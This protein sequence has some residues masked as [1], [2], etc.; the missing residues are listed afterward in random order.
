MIDSTLTL[1]NASAGGGISNSGALTVGNTI[2]SNNR[3]NNSG[4]AITNIASATLTISGGFFSGNTAKNGGAI[5][6]NSA[7]ATLTGVSL[8][9]D[10]ASSSAAPSTTSLGT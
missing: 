3:A 2:F 5:E 6:N 8:S 1:N 10:T 4:G 7:T 9:G